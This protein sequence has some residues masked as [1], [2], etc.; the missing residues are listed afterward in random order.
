MKMI[1]LG[2][3]AWGRAMGAALQRNGHQVIYWGREEQGWPVSEKIDLLFVAVPTQAIRERFQSLKVPQVPLVGLSKGIEL[4]TGYRVSQILNQVAPGCPVACLS[5]P[6][7]AREVEQGMPTAVV[8]ASHDDALV[9]LVQQAVHSKVLRVYRS[10]DLAGVEAGG[11]LKNVFAIAGG[12]CQGLQIGENGMAGLMARSLAEMAR[13]T[14]AMGGRA[15]TVFGLGGLGDLILTAYSGHSRNHQ[16][17]EGLGRGQKLADILKNLGG[18]AEGVPT[19]Q[20][21]YQ[22]AQ[23]RGLKAPITAE[24]F[25]VLYQAKDPRRAMNDLLTRDPSEE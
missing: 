1:V 4:T 23:T 6:S 22:M 24:V 18:V 2:R 8:V 21:V 14:V 12:I 9:R 19:S 25:A 10:N 11:A 3:G 15:E 7:L 17:G 5:G 13:L 16:V 20:A